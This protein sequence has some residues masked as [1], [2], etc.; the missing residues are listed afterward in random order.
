MEIE[1]VAL[2]AGFVYEQHA[3]RFGPLH[4]KVEVIVLRKRV[5]G[6]DADFTAIQAERH[7]RQLK[8]RRSAP[9]GW[10]FDGLRFDLSSVQLE[11]HAAR[12][13]RG[14]VAR[15]SRLHMRLAGAVNSARRPHA[16]DREVT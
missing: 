5:A 1:H 13:L 6:I 16:F 7:I 3:P 8:L 15:D 14:S 4:R 10:Y 9:A 11:R 12:G 2:A